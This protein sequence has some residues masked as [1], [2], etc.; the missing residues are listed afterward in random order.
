MSDH[1]PLLVDLDLISPMDAA[2]MVNGAGEIVLSASGG[3]AAGDAGSAANF[4]INVKFKKRATLPDGHTHLIMRRTE[5][6]GVHTY[7]VKATAISTLLRDSATGQAVIVARATIS[8]ITTPENP[9]VIDVNATL[10]VTVDDNG[11]PGIGADTIGF[12]VLSSGNALWFSSNGNGTAVNQVIVGGN[13][14]VR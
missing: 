13:L 2:A 1:N 14:L 6:D 7:Q 5:M 12:T 9:I 4:A 11:N 3:L 8:D 10:R